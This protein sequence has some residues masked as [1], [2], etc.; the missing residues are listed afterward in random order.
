M[1]FADKLL[2]KCLQVEDLDPSSQK[3]FE[4]SIADSSWPFQTGH[5]CFILQLTKSVRVSQYTLKQCLS[6]FQNQQ[7][8][9]I[10]NDEHAGSQLKPCHSDIGH[11]NWY[12]VS[13]LLQSVVVQVVYSTFARLI[14]TTRPL[15]FLKPNF[16]N[17]PIQAI[18]IHSPL[19]IRWVYFQPMQCNLIVI[20]SCIKVVQTKWT[21][22]DRRCF[23]WSQVFEKFGKWGFHKCGVIADQGH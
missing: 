18:L 7:S 21:V 10:D 4:S 6:L 2:F 15:T 8:M 13:T 22:D 19:Q 1:S 5:F 12:P 3:K 11:S 16:F 23:Q 14:S 17:K 9:L 20:Y